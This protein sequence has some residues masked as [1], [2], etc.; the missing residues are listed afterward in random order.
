MQVKQN[1]LVYMAVL[2]EID[3]VTPKLKPSFDIL[4]NSCS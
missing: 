1:T 2:E 3:E 4:H